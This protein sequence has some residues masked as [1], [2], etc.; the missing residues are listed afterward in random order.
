MQGAFGFTR[1]VAVVYSPHID[2]QPRFFKSL[3][4]RLKSLHETREAE[5]HLFLVSTR[6]PLATR[7][8]DK[9][10]E[11]SEFTAIALPIGP[12]ERTVAHKIRESI[13]IRLATRNLYDERDPVTGKNFFGRK[14]LLAQLVEE[15]RQGNVCGVFG[16]RKTG[17]TSLIAEL[18]KRFLL[19]NPRSRIFILYDLESLLSDSSLIASRLT[20]GLRNLF[21]QELRGRGARTRELQS[22]PEAAELDQLHRALQTSL[23]H[24]RQDDIQVILALDEV[25]SLIGDADEIRHGAREKV[26][27]VLGIIRALVQQNENFSVIFSGITSSLIETGYLYGRE[28]P[29]FSWAKA[30][31]IPPMTKPEISD[32]TREVGHRM[33]LNWSA[34]A[35]D[36][37][38]EISDGNV[39]IHRTVATEIVNAFDETADRTVTVENVNRGLKIWRRESSQILAE[40][41]ASARRHYPD[42][43]ELL[44]LFFDDRETFDY[45]ESSQSS[46]I[47]RLVKLSLLRDSDNGQLMASAFSRLLR[48][49]G[50]I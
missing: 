13:R 26:P 38:Y 4:D 11:E 37:M 9:W 10:S 22:L 21:L 40:M 43:V 18:G 19:Q 25:E 20:D 3:P 1:D 45:F 17:K 7:K 50:A 12:D 23:R 32:L 30:Y 39:Y 27:E 34:D 14:Q 15:L 16:L 28:N 6:D 36:R 2:L 31:Y 29:L 41:L 46:K 42:E 49:V 35:L 8:L 47:G 24:C 5:D 48:E 44:E 33:Y